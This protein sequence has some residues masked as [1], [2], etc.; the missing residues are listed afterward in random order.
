VITKGAEAM[1]DIFAEDQEGA[2]TEKP[3]EGDAVA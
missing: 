3:E 2:E 1:D